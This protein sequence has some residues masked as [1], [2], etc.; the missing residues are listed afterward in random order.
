MVEI[1]GQAKIDG[2]SLITLYPRHTASKYC[3]AH[4]VLAF[5]YKINMLRYSW[6]HLISR[7]AYCI[8]KQVR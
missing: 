4:I 6:H 2:A 3:R 5:I 8:K 1:M 7:G